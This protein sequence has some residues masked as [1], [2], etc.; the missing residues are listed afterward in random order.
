MNIKKSIIPETTVSFNEWCELYKVGTRHKDFFRGTNHSNL[1][2][3]YDFTKFKVN[4]PES[5]SNFLVGFIKYI[6]SF[7]T[8]PILNIYR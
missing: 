6:H 5:Q 3:C 4:K 1:N 2:D 7:M 8:K